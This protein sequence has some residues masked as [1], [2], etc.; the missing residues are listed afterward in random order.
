[1]QKY[2]TRK[3]VPE[4]YKWDLSDLYKNDLDFES[5]YKLSKDNIKK[6]K[7]FVGCTK[8]SKKLYEFLDLDIN[9]IAIIERL[10]IYSYL[11]ND[12]E[13]GNSKSMERKN[14]AA[15]LINEYS[16]SIS[17]FAPELLNLD[18]T[19]YNDLFKKNPSLLEFKKSLDDI[20]RSKKYILSQEK[21]DIINALTNAL[22]H[23][24]D[25]SSTMLNSEHNYGSINIDGKDTVITPTNY[26]LLMK[27]KSRNIREEVRKKYNEKLGEYLVSSA[28]FLNA[29]VK[30][31]L[32]VSK[33]HGYDNAWDK[34]LFNLRLS[35]KVFK[36]LVEVIEKNTKSLQKYF[37]VFKDTLKLNELYQYDLDLEL[38]LSKEEYSI[39]Q[40]QDICL[41]A[42]MPLGTDYVNHF[43]KII[44]ERC[45]DY[46]EYKGKCSGGYSYA[47]LDR[48]S[49]ILMSFNYDLDSVSTLIHE[50][51]HNVHHQ[52]IKD[53]NPL[54]YREVPSIV[55]EVASLTNECLL[56]NYLAN[57]GNTKEEKLSGIAN[58]LNVII[59]NL[60]GAVREGKM[61][62]DFYDYVSEGNM[63]NKDY[64]NELT[65]SSLKHYYGKEVNLDEYSKY[66]WARRSHYY[67]DYYLY[68]YA[69]CIA[70]ATYGVKKII[71]GD[72]EY[73]NKYLE[74]LKTG[75]DK[76]PEEI[77]AIL[78]ISLE[79]KKVYESAIKYFD[80]LIEEF[81]KI[82]KGSA[83]NG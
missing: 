71:T 56:S 55:C 23:F 36:T 53:N 9:T 44:D 57:N 28:N 41:K 20:Y 82:N 18:T 21:E 70:V 7:E 45:V 72:K 74:F 10:Y 73:L 26:R 76:T 47:P 16:L 78:G 67:M 31:N 37:R 51:G 80:D 64:M 52:Y 81:I 34:K 46:A 42:V 61:E 39:E 58:I 2:K 4:K 11:V 15:D 50:G 19:S 1:M 43:K 33:I 32:T 63:I 65:L 13:L 8:D 60:F 22:D 79:D 68:S 25:F 3:D 14:K 24:D 59:S 75:S 5:D 12:Q 38:A 29:H 27:N 69:I 40:A 48:N 77:F 54:Q 35:D 6:L 49:K 30:T 17:F 66:S 62:Q 83:N